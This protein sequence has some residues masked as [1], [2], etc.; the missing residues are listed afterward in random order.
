MARSDKSSDQ[1]SARP[2]GRERTRLRKWMRRLLVVLVIVLL[3]PF[4]LVP[5]YMVVPPPISSLM[6]WRMAQGYGI[7]RYWTPIEQ[8]SPNLIDAVLSSEDG[9]FCLHQGVDWQ[10]VEIVLDDLIDGGNPRG[11]STLTMQTVKNLFLWPS[12]SYLRKALE[13]PLALYADLFWSKRR[14]VEIYL[15]V[16]EWGPGLYGAEAAARRYFGKTAARLSMREASLLATALP[17]PLARNPRQPGA[18]HTRLARILE[19]RARKSA[20]L[21]SCVGNR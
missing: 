16:A 2:A 12:R 18:A 7:N 14:I 13:I 3:A 6:V 4:I 21:F 19:A 10:A 17:N 1:S 9:R 8:F 15:N 11:A 20:G 5:A